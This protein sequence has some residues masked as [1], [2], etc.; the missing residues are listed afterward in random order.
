MF[1]YR[2]LWVNT[3]SHFPGKI[4][5]EYG[6]WMYGSCM[7]SFLKKLPSSFPEWLYHFT[8]L[9]SLSFFLLNCGLPFVYGILIGL[10]E[11]QCGKD[12]RNLAG[13]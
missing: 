2:F 7:D 11:S 6:C 10:N 12:F 9:V 3:N 1:M 5:R 8:F 4:P 13:T